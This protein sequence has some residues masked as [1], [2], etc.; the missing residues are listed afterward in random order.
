MRAGLI[1]AATAL[2]MGAAA[3]PVASKDIDRVVLSPASGK[4]FEVGDEK[5]VGYYLVKK[6]QCELTLMVAP[7]G[8]FDTIKGAG[9][10]FRFAVSPG[11]AGVFES[12]EGRALQFTC[13]AGAKSMTVQ[14]FQRVAYTDRKAG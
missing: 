10:R 9:A 2:L 4:S 3:M 12:P 14:S 7:V 13:E 6:G 8:D 1:A 5:T 11:R